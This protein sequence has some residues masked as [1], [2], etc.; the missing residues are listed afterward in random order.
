M[1]AKQ[2]GEGDPVKQPSQLGNIVKDALTE[3]G[4]MLDDIVIN[5]QR[6]ADKLSS[7]WESNKEKSGYNHFKNHGQNNRFGFMKI[8]G[9]GNENG[10]FSNR[11]IVNNLSVDANDVGMLI[12]VGGAGLAG[13]NSFFKAAHFLQT[14]IGG[15]SGGVSLGGKIEEWL[16]LDKVTKHT[17]DGFKVVNPNSPYSYGSNKAFY[18]EPVQRDTFLIESKIKN[19]NWNNF[20]SLDSINKSKEA[21]MWNNKYKL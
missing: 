16:G 20:K 15:F 10:G 4:T 14:A 6:G 7:D 1:S 21:K 9:N 3:M 12:N 2:P 18:I 19:T 17:F 8:Y 5:V 11:G 13:A